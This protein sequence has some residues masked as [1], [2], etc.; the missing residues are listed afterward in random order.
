MEWGRP[1]SKQ[2]K[3]EAIMKPR[4]A[5]LAMVT[6]LIGLA[7][8]GLGIAAGRAPAGVTRLEGVQ[9][10][11][12]VPG[13]GHI[14]I[15]GVEDQNPIRHSIYRSDDEGRSWQLLSANLPGKITVLAGDGR[16]LYVGTESIGVVKSTDGGL[17]WTPSSEGLGPMPNA[18]VTALTVDDENPDVLYASIGY[19]LGTSQAHFAPM[20]TWVST[21]GGGS[22]A[23]MNSG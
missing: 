18:T 7:I 6:A 23:Q 5:L 9:T 16:T 22:W 11:I 1:L 17:S 21:N 12:V 15:A 8:G 20:G 3:G 13:E 4:M 10:M 2:V 14:M 19:Y